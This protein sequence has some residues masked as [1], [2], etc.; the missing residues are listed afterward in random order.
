M[1]NF[2]GGVDGFLE[3]ALSVS[4][5]RGLCVV[6]RELGVPRRRSGFARD[7]GG[8]GE[9]HGELWAAITVRA[10]SG[11]WTYTRN[12]RNFS[13]VKCNESDQKGIFRPAANRAI[14]LSAV[15]SLLQRLSNC[16]KARRRQSW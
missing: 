2:G 7:A 8:V 9:G 14:V 11:C 6:F 4:G 1:S 15:L 16:V 13:R 10:P 3:T 5:T 12:Y